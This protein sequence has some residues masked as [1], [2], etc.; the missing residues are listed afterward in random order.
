LIFVA[1]GAPEQELWIAR[2]LHRLS[3]MV[4]IGVGGVFDTIAGRLS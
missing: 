2:L 3:P 1:L 4:A